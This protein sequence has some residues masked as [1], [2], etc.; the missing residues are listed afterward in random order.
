MAFYSL[1]VK[2]S[3]CRGNDQ[4]L[5]RVT[6]PI[7]TQIVKAQRFKKKYIYIYIL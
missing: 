7:Q 2:F 5:G 1:W 6:V 4:H 3:K